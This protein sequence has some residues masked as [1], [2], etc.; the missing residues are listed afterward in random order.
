M[1]YTQS[2]SHAKAWVIEYTR[3]VHAFGGLILFIISQTAIL[4]AWWSRNKIVF[5]CLLGYQVIFLIIRTFYRLN[6]LHIASVA[7][8]PQTENPE[9]KDHLR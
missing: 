8:D 6:P 5:Y 2:S 7:K 4:S 1:K 9:A 3:Y